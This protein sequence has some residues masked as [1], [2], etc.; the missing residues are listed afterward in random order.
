MPPCSGAWGLFTHE[1]WNLAI[2]KALVPALVFVALGPLNPCCFG[3]S[4]GHDPLLLLD[5]L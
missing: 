1:A 4:C 5:V 3:N 2:S